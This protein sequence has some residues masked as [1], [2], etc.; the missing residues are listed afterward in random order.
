MET[1]PFVDACI[2]CDAEMAAGEEH[3]NVCTRCRFRAA[4]DLGGKVVDIDGELRDRFG[5][6]S[7]RP[8]QRNV[9]EAVMNGRDVVFVTG[10]GSGKTLCYQLPA[11][12]SRGVALVISPLVSLIQDQIG[13]LDSLGIGNVGFYPVGKA[14]PNVETK[15]IIERL[16]KQDHDLIK[17]ILLTPEKLM[18]DVLL[19]PAIQRLYREGCLSMIVF[20]EVHCLIEWGDG[21]RQSYG[22]AA[23]IRTDWE[24]THVP[25]LGL[26]ASLSRTDGERL[27]RRLNLCDPEIVIGNLN[28]ENITYEI[29]EKTRSKQDDAQARQIAKRIR[30]FKQAQGIVYCHS[31]YDCEEL[32]ASLTLLLRKV[33]PYYHAN[34]DESE[35]IL[36]QKEFTQG[37]H[38]VLVA[39]SAFGMG[40]DK[41]GMSVQGK[42]RSANRILISPS[43]TDVRYV[44]HATMPL[45]VAQF[46]Q[47]S[48]RA[49]R[50]G[51]PAWSVL[52][53]GFADLSRLYGVID[54]ANATLGNLNTGRIS[55]CEPS[56]I[57]R[58]L[59]AA[60]QCAKLFATGDDVSCCV[61][62]GILRAFEV[63][64]NVTA[65]RRPT[66]GVGCCTHCATAGVAGRS[67]RYDVTRELQAMDA[68][69]PY[70]DLTLLQAVSF[71]RGSAARLTG[72][73]HYM[74]GHEWY[75]SLRYHRKEETLMLVI[76][77]LI[78]QN[79][80]WE[81]RINIRAVIGSRTVMRPLFYLR[82]SK[83]YPRRQLTCALLTVKDLPLR[84]VQEGATPV[85]EGMM[86]SGA[87]SVQRNEDG[88]C[89][90]DRPVADAEGGLTLP[91]IVQSSA[92]AALPEIVR[93]SCEEATSGE[94]TCS[95]AGSEPQ[96][97][98]D[99][100]SVATSISSS[101]TEAS[102]QRSSDGEERGSMSTSGSTSVA[103]VSL[104]QA[105]TAS[106]TEMLSTTSS[107]AAFFSQLSSSEST[108]GSESLSSCSRNSTLQESVMARQ[109]TESEIG[110]D[111]RSSRMSGGGGNA[112]DLHV[113][114][115]S[116]FDTMA[117]EAW[118]RD[119]SGSCYFYVRYHPLCQTAIMQTAL[120]QPSTVEELTSIWR[121]TAQLQWWYSWYG[122]HI[123]ERNQDS[124]LRCISEWRR[125]ERRL[126]VDEGT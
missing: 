70:H 56:G 34:R 91:E 90:R 82:I 17:I 115:I 41:P 126:R 42:Q 113:K 33:V 95:L 103:S 101:I 69:L 12:C 19:K 86:G 100:A 107:N 67:K 116:L 84:I 39:T 80:L 58:G 64:F 10:T 22:D 50:D 88:M 15:D 26:T 83:R 49:G 76:A 51:L 106:S 104:W 121:S 117:Y 99:S 9:I 77:G 36:I 6:E 79:Y 14:K 24:L 97:N 4:F 5:H 38:K 46:Y 110:S 61:R 75:G 21:F 98:I 18:K 57:V 66:H 65:L 96:S 11:L 52:F 63:K 47:E 43:D 8:C 120:G 81:E 118:Q 108:H 73:R 23:R 87:A 74:R 78:Q 94:T 112:L 30:R 25:I 102:R 60:K 53:Y 40:I 105:S 72:K 111:G 29:I 35:R 1:E 55:T 109:R 20:D 54:P 124:I 92:S 16:K 44:I 122:C 7:F 13:K 59:D 31:R 62:E 32:A 93:S 71:F 2:I 28:R 3:G 37:K 119:K 27:C 68:V 45:S 114:L 85:E 48:G 89:R 125:N 123:L